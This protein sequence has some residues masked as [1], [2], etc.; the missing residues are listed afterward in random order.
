MKKSLFFLILL[1]INNSIAQIQ[2]DESTIIDFIINDNTY[3]ESF[4]NTGSIIE[5][6]T[7]VEKCKYVC[8]YEEK[9]IGFVKENNE[10]GCYLISSIGTR[11]LI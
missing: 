10:E 2:T 8:A 9:C 5:K 6:E 4:S 7:D 11:I 3:P 1:E